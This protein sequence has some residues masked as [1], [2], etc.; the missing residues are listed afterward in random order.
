[1][2]STLV[3]GAI[4]ALD[5]GMHSHYRFKPT[6]LAVHPHDSNLKRSHL[7][8]DPQPRSCNQLFRRFVENKR[9]S[10]STFDS[11]FAVASLVVVVYDW[12][13]QQ[14]AYR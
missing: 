2:L 3:Y 14:Y 12:G 1:M 11:Y 5:G 13:V 4:K 10:H 9:R 7:V 8:A 6:V